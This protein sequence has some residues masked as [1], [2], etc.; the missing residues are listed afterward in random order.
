MKHDLPYFAHYSTTH[1]EPRTQALLEE[2]GFEGYGR[3][4]IL[5]EIIASSPDAILNISSRVIKLTI[6]RALGLGADEFDNFIG[7]LSAPDIN[8]IQFKNDIITTDFL[9]ENYYT[10]SKKRQ[11]DRDSYH[12]DNDSSTVLPISSTENVQ[13]KVNESKKE[14]S[15]SDENAQKP[16]PPPLLLLNVKSKIA[17]HD[18]FLDDQEIENLVAKTD[19]AWFEAHSFIDFIAETVRQGYS[20]KPKRERHKI[21][22]KLLFDAQNLREEY[23]QWR[24]QQEKADTAKARE[25]AKMAKPRT[26]PTCGADLKN[27]ELGC[28]GHGYF[29]F[30]EAAVKYQFQEY[31]ENC[32]SLAE[33]FTKHMAEKKAANL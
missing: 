1:N 30:N 32:G 16:P 3:Y 15:S 19:P 24:E 29:E 6:A 18:F 11:R 27:G 20:G 4:W 33:E 8:L 10:V 22:R 14:N 9:Q 13:S 21:F 2:H 26:C 28:P 5:C 17:D 12:S 23:P 7:F 25:K 31:S